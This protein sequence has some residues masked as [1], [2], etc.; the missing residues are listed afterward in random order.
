MLTTLYCP[1]AKT[2]VSETIGVSSKTTKL[3]TTK[4]YS[5]MVQD[6]TGGIGD[7]S[8]IDC[9]LGMDWAAIGSTGAVPVAVTVFVYES[10]EADSALL[11]ASD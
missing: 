8:S 5:D 3:S 6:L 11:R 2:I 1:L 9:L 10:W 7:P 4:D